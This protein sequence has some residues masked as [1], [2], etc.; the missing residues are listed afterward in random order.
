MICD[1]Q[2]KASF[3]SISRVK[4]KLW[5]AVKGLWKSISSVKNSCLNGS[6]S[7]LFCGVKPRWKHYLKYVSIK[8]IKKLVICLQSQRALSNMVKVCVIVTQK[9][10]TLCNPHFDCIKMCNYYTVWPYYYITEG[11][12]DSVLLTS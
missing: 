11:R 5:K 2:W 12:W 8:E 7:A 4:I 3:K 9:L 1:R 6:E 10:H